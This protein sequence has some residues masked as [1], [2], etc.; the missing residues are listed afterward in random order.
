MESSKKFKENSTT[1]RPKSKILETVI[2]KCVVSGRLI[3]FYLLGWTNFLKMLRTLQNALRG[4]SF[5]EN[6]KSLSCLVAEM[7]DRQ[8][9]I[10]VLKKMV[11]VLRIG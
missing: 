8:G 11:T 1:N 10:K 6:L 4:T 5:S 7:T 2:A 3:F 9:I